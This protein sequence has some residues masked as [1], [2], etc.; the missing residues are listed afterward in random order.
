MIKT[1]FDIFLSYKSEDSEWVTTL[2]KDLQRRGVQVWLDRDEIRP[3]DLFVGALEDGLASSRSVGLVVTPES[4]ASGWVKEE[5]SRALSLVKESSLQLI[6]LILKDAELPGFIKSRHFVDFRNNDLYESEV[7][8]LVWPGITGESITFY[9]IHRVNGGGPFPW[10]ALE[11]IISEN[12]FSTSGSDYCRYSMK[13]RI[14]NLNVEGKRI[15]SIVDIFE[16][17][18]W[19]ERSVEEASYY[20]NTIFEIR[21]ITKDKSNEVVFILYNHPDAFFEAKHTLKPEVVARFKHYFS[22]PK[23]FDDYPYCDISLENKQMLESSFRSVWYK[24]QG[25]LLRTSRL[26]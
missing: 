9:S 21:E 22:I 15:V 25:E 18:P 11:K 2:K 14:N 6:P 20:A 1:P 10:P 12:G 13:D 26:R 23:L 19:R 17:W 3:G 8:K 4:I 5:Y 24:V 16:D 7:N